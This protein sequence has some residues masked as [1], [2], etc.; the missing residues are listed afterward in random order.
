[1]VATASV[2]L[3]VVLSGCAGNSGSAAFRSVRTGMSEST[4]RS[5]LGKPSSFLSSTHAGTTNTCWYYAAG[6]GK[7]ETDRYR[8]CFR[9]GK[10][11]EKHAF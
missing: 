3:T 5:I 7:I 4:V 1:M 6:H 8:V 2:L 11:D 10:V 9:N